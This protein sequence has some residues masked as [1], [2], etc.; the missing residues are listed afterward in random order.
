MVLGCAHLMMSSWALSTIFLLWIY[1]RTNPVIRKLNDRACYSPRNVSQTGFDHV[2]RSVMWKWA[3]VD[4]SRVLLTLCLSI[5]LHDMFVLTALETVLLKF[6]NIFTV[7]LLEQT[8]GQHHFNKLV[9][10]PRRGRCMLHLLFGLLISASVRHNP[11]YVASRIMKS[12][13]NFN[14]AVWL[15]MDNTDSNVCLVYYSLGFIYISPAISSVTYDNVILIN[16]P[17]DPVKTICSRSSEMGSWKMN[18]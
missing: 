2:K 12:L 18:C 9:L 8:P 14:Q 6:V 10:C 5:W 17:L 13:R 3:E 15:Y 16:N 4:W 1:Q 7:C 11:V